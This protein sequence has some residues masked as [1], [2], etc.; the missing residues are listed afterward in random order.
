MSLGG[1]TFRAFRPSYFAQPDEL[2]DVEYQ[3][4]QAKILLYI[5][6]AEAGQ[7]LFQQVNVLNAMTGGQNLRA[8]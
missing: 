4:K 1:Q 2:E 3:A 7:P 6:R 5:R 8:M